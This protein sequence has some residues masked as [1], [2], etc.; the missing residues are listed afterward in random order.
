VMA[1]RVCQRKT[2]VIVD[3][4]RQF[5]FPGA[6]RL[7]LELG[8]SIVVRPG[9]RRD[10]Y[11][12]IVQSLRSSAVGAVVSC[13]ERLSMRQLRRLQLAAEAGGGVAILLRPAAAL[14]DLSCASVR[15]LVSPCPSLPRRAAAV[16]RPSPIVSPA[17]DHTDVMRHVRVELL[18][19]RGRAHGESVVLEIDDE[20]G[21]VHTPAAMASATV[22]ARSAR[23]SG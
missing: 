7:G 14:R 19:C 17:I 10:A 21:H 23:A 12:A 8:R 5:Y 16:S 13:Q 3:A 4:D 1:T 11:Q 18:R 2:L 20:T 22:M 6:V 9:S 15:L